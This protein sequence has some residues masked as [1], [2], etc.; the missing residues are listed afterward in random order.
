MVHGIYY[1]VQYEIYFN[2]ELDLFNDILPVCIDIRKMLSY[3]KISSNSN[4]YKLVVIPYNEIDQ[5]LENNEHIRKYMME[6]DAV[7]YNHKKINDSNFE[8]MKYYN[9]QI[10]KKYIKHDP[11]IKPFSD[12][13]FIN[14]KNR[15]DELIKMRKELN[16]WEKYTADEQAAFDSKYHKLKIALQVQQIIRNEAYFNEIKAI[17]QDLTNIQLTPGENNLIN[18]IINHPNLNGH[19]SWHG[20]NLIEGNY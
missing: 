9:V 4:G 14:I 15:I 12:V 6:N 11:S 5:R 20:F 18:S 2:C 1:G 7:V 8:E 13:E 10:Y 19:I 17:E 3:E 16:Y